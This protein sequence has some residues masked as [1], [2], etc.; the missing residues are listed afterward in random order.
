MTEQT[1]G[2]CW[3][4]RKASCM[5]N[6]SRSVASMVLFSTST[7]WTPRH[8][9]WNSLELSGT[10]SIQWGVVRAHLNYTVSSLNTTLLS[11]G[12]K[13]NGSRSYGDC[14]SCRPHAQVSWEVLM[15]LESD[16][17]LHCTGPL[18]SG[19]P[20]ESTKLQKRRNTPNHKHELPGVMLKASYFA[21]VL[22]VHH[23]L[24]CII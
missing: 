13:T 2:W 24:K 9:P 18:N 8:I 20:L 14:H 10:S 12:S 22:R 6:I 3:R 21:H 4:A 16:I 5:T 19:R 17:G 11:R 15:Q 1:L 7:H 23:Q